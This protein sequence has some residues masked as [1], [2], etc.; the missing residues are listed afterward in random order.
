MESD[1]S[2]RPRSRDLGTLCS[3]PPGPQGAGAEAWEGE[4]PV[5]QPSLPFVSMHTLAR[6]P[7]TD[8][9]VCMCAR[10]GPHR[11]TLV[12][13]NACTHPDTQRAQRGSA[14]APGTGPVTGQVPAPSLA[15]A[16]Q[17]PRGH[18]A[19]EEGPF[20]MLVGVWQSGF[21]HT[22][23]LTKLLPVE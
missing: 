3:P 22:E 5:S 15:P 7:Q 10:A 23:S 14:G 12:H 4:I 9:R 11:P 1:R 13:T 2:H 20:R 18:L 8:S 16:A 17:R 21:S 6:L 19:R